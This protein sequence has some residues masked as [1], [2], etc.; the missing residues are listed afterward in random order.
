MLSNKTVLIPIDR[1]RVDF[2][3]GMGIPFSSFDLIVLK[4]IAEEPRRSIAD[5]AEILS[6]PQRILVES[7]VSLTRAGLVA[8]GRGDRAFEVTRA[9]QTSIE[10]GDPPRPEH[11]EARQGSVVLDRL[12][13]QVATLR[14]I[15]YWTTK[16]LQETMVD[17]HSIWDRAE[18]LKRN[19]HLPLL[20][21]GRAKPLLRK[22][23][24]AN[25]WIRWIAN[26]I[27]QYEAWLKIQINANGSVTGIPDVWRSALEPMLAELL[28]PLG[29]DVQGHQGGEVKLSPTQPVSYRWTAVPKQLDFVKGGVDHWTSLESVFRTAKSQLLIA[30]A[31][32]SADIIEKDLGPL[33][34]AAVGRGVRVDLMW[35]YSKGPSED[36]K[37]VRALKAIRSTCHG[38]GNLL[39]F[40]EVATG[41]HAKLLIWD[42][43]NGGFLASVGSNNWLSA[44]QADY[45]T[46]RFESS[47]RLHHSGVIADLCST[48]AGL[49][50]RAEAPLS[51]ASDI[52]H[53]TASD[54]ER[55]ETR[56]VERA[57]IHAIDAS[58]GSPH[59]DSP[60]LS[61]VRDLE[62]ESVIRELLLG[63]SKRA[64][65]ASHRLGPKAP[66]RLASARH[67][68]RVPGHVIDLKV[69]VGSQP[70]DTVAFSEA[71]KLVS[72]MGGVLKVCLGVHAKLVVADDI[73]LI[74]SF[75]PLSA[76]PFGTA[77][78]AREVGILVQSTAFADAA[79]AWIGELMQAADA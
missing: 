54:L 26:P 49:W 72:D 35:G 23:S 50:S 42:D 51:G 32:A 14:D 74:G 76:D 36:A 69:V 33:V 9:G 61:V 79:W 17:G 45:G 31:F 38:N 63:A 37:I 22:G 20:D 2:E 64:G 48:V 75:N 57:G 73:V 70:E 5:L 53:R 44:G 46:H 29:A 58:A 68:Q 16:R 13:G 62:H 4:A 25:G 34:A 71:S 40:N 47:I 78:N 12:T 11:I 60:N 28:G 19:P 24:E 41:S 30:S 21:A 55:L 43:A 3:V 7:M 77:E 56:R 59:T 15:S 67:R 10:S 8:V 39:R 65:I 18:R 6:L 66:I 27:P 52:W 1:Y